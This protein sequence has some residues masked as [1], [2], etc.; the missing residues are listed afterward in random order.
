MKPERQ[1]TQSKRSKAQA[2]MSLLEVTIALA[3][4][5]IVSVNILTMSLLAMKTTESQ[6][7]LSART[8]EYAQDKMEQ[9]LSLAFGDQNSDTTAVSN[10]TIVV[11]SGTGKGLQVGGSA[12]PTAPVAGYVDYLDADGNPSTAAGNWYYIRVW[13]ISNVAGVP[14]VVVNGVLSPSAKVITVTSR[15]RN[16]VGG[17]GLLPQSTVSAGISYPF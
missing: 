6:G 3:I 11:G 2:G 8:A 1:M 5:L 15:V 16:S 17:K 12:D 13:Q 10:G 7:H 14:N 9:L 4:L